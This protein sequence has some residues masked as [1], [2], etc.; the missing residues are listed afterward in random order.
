[1]ATERKTRDAWDKAA[2]VASLLVPISV[3]FVGILGTYFLHSQQATEAN[4]R[5]LQQ[6]AET[7]G[8]LYVELQTSREKADSDLRK[9]M[10][11][12]VITTFLKRESREPAELILALELLAYNFHEVID[13]GPLFKHVEAMLRPIQPETLREQYGKRLERA[14]AEVTDKQL[15]A[16]KDASTIAYDD[17]FFDLL[18]AHP[19]GIH[20]FDQSMN[21]VDGNGGIIQLAETSDATTF[22][23]VD[24][25][26]ADEKNKELR[27]RL[28]V[29]HVPRT[30]TTPEK[31]PAI[32][33]EIDIDFKVGFYDFP[34]IDNTRLA[35]GRRIAVVL[36]SWEPGR[37]EIA[38]AYFP[39]S[40]ASL[41]EKPYYEELIEQLH[42]SQME[43]GG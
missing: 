13:L 40:R 17:V 1:M 26:G 6:A 2:V 42:P 32:V 10:F 37:A 18:D 27:I 8:R 43:K 16:L 35:N 33:T 23:Q 21:N 7:R 36:R 25:L 28:W 12:T 38:L 11:D 9:S 19:E 5:L 20:V 39:G 31:A 4:S 14:A 24:V 34:M 22:A 29:Y 3:A 30:A 41:K 15:A